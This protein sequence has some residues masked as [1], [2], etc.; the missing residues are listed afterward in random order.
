MHKEELQHERQVKQV[1]LSEMQRLKQDFEDRAHQYTD[2]SM[3]KSTLQHSKSTYL[4]SVGQKRNGM[5]TGIPVNPIN[6]QYDLNYNGDQFRI[7]EDENRLNKALR[8]HHLVKRGTCGYNVINGKE[9]IGAESR[10]EMAERVR[11]YDEYYRV[12]PN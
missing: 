3:A 8:E 2:E 1:K 7:R 4:L 9:N 11:E 6:H 5:T 12:R 10:V